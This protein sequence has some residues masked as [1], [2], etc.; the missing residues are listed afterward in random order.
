MDFLRHNE[1]ILKSFGIHFTLSNVLDVIERNKVLRLGRIKIPLC[2]DKHGMFELSFECIEKFI[3]NNET[4][5]VLCRGKITNR[6]Y[7]NDE[8]I[9]YLKELYPDK[10]Y[11][12]TNTIFKGWKEKVSII[13]PIHGEFWRLPQRLDEGRGCPYCKESLLERRLRLFFEEQGI[14]YIFQYRNKLILG[15]KSLDFFLPDYSVGIECQ[16]L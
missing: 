3:K 13:C 16:G 7:S 1:Q 14:Q 2:C 6:Q 9:S 5:C 15:R 12:Y 4:P 8:F 11:D 10:N